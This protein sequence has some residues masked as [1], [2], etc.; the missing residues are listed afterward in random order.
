[1]ALQLNL[2]NAQAQNYPE[3]YARINEYWGD[4]VVI[5][6][7]VL[8]FENQTAYQNNE[9]PIEKLTFEFPYIDNIEISDMYNQLKTEPLFANAI[10]V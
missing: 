9:P 2:T 6:F 10:E 3:S 4:D 8:F 7:E 5:R 1:M